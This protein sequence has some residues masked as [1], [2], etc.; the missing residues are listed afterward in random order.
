MS[1]NVSRVQRDSKV[2]VVNLPNVL[3]VLRLVLVPVFIVL[4]LTAVVD[5][6]VGGIRRLRRRRDHGPLRRGTRALVGADHRLR[7]H[8][9][10][11][12]RQGPDPVR[13]RS[14]VLPGV[15]ALVA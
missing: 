4:G 7:P 13:L 6:A 11:Y 1:D 3:T 14:A 10:P 15:P 2:P 12:R 8:R 9:R 5:R